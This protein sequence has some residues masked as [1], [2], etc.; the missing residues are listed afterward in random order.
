[1]FAVATLGFTAMYGRTLIG[2]LEVN[3]EPGQP[4]IV[5]SC[6]LVFFFPV[7]A[8]SSFTPQ[9]VQHVAARG[10]PP[11]RA[12]GLV[13]GISTLGN[14]L[15]VLLTAFVLIP[16]SPVSTLLVTWMIVALVSLR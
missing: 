1:M 5:L 4:P 11:G 10:V 7:L 2:T 13:Y 16:R 12:S 8:L 3:M 15:G 14:I 9:C 6:V